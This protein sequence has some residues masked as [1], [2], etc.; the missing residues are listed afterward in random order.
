MRML[1]W[2]ESGGRQGGVFCS[3]G[4]L[5]RQD[6]QEM[7]T[8]MVPNLTN[9]GGS[10]GI[11]GDTMGISSLQRP[12]VATSLEQWFVRAAVT[13]CQQVSSWCSI[14]IFTS[15]Q[16]IYIYYYLFTID[17]DVILGFQI[18]RNLD[19]PSFRWVLPKESSGISSFS[20]RVGY[21]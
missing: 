5:K 4:P 7:N 13:E 14:Y 8:K 15:I 11:E 6:L 12:S 2:N 18:C 19:H 21:V 20:I 9:N 17:P 3:V 10:T 16:C 1:N